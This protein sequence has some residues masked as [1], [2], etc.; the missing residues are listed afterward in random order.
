MRTPHEAIGTA[1]CETCI[2]ARAV[3]IED[4][5]RKGEVTATREACECHIARPIRFGFPTVRLDDFCANHVDRATLEKT[6]AGLAPS[7]FGVSFS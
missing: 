2:F 6:F 3:T 5:N 7:T 4:K 1:R